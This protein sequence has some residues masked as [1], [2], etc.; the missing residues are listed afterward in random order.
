MRRSGVRL[1]SAPPGATDEPFE[2]SDA[3]PSH[4]AERPLSALRRL[5]QATGSLDIR[6]AEIV[7]CHAAIEKEVN[8]ALSKRVANPER[9]GG[10]NL[11]HS[12]KKLTAVWTTSPSKP[13]ADLLTQWD[14]L[15]NH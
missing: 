4:G 8:L 2:M 9:L 15:R 6:T 1:P 12:L 3:K 13:L 7:I 10:L 11:I 5:A 14:E